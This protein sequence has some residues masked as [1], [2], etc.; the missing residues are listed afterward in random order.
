MLLSP[1]ATIRVKL[2]RADGLGT[3]RV[4]SCYCARAC[5]VKPTAM[6]RVA[7]AVQRFSPIIETLP[8]PDLAG[9]SALLDETNR[10]LAQPRL[11]LF[12]CQLIIIFQSLAFK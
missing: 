8:I 5:P 4:R 1:I 9:W 10:K 3:T 6:A 11:S 7:A 2:L 12:F